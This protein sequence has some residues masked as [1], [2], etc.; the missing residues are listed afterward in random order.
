MTS[1]IFLNVSKYF[2][3]CISDS[4]KKELY[5]KKLYKK[6]PKIGGILFKTKTV[7][8]RKIR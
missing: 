4:Y 2:L 5:L 8:L 7:I 3:K 1:I 6:S